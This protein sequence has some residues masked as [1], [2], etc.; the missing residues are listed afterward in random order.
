MTNPVWALPQDNNG[1][2]VQLPLPTAGG[3]T[4][5]TGSLIFGIGTQTN[6]GLGS[7]IVF[8]VDAN[9][10]FTTTFNGQLPANNCSYIDS[11]SNAFFFPSSGYPG[12][13]ACTGANSSF[14]CPANDVDFERN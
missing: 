14:Y 12:L 11:G 2:L 1:T 13:V 3:S 6:N 8:Q 10:Y 5:L 9:A 4:T 7:A